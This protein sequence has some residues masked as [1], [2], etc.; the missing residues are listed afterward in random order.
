MR[1]KLPARPESARAAERWHPERPV[2]QGQSS[3][4]AAYQQR[5]RRALRELSSPARSARQE[6]WSWSQEL[7]PRRAQFARRALPE[8]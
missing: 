7:L 6:W 8:Q 1:V 4:L 3:S 2:R 5:E